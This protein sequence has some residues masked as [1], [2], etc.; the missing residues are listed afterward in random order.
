M[1]DGEPMVFRELGGAMREVVLEGA[2]LPSRGVSNAVT[3]RKVTTWYPGRSTA[4]TQRMGTS[5]DPIRMSGFW[6]DALLAEVNTTRETLRQDIRSL[7]RVGFEIEL[8]WGQH[9]RR[10]FIDSFDAEW[11]TDGRGAWTMTFGP[12][13]SDDDYVLST[14]NLPATSESDTKRLLNDVD[15]AIDTLAAT[16]G[17][18]GGIAAAVAVIF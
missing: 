6:S 8:E 16:A 1:A 18:L 12:N 17:A 5:E 13:E 10:G 14:V 3:T 7:Q 4:S 9:I 11:D 2:A 15:S